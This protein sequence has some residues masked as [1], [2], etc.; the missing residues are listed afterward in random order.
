MVAGAAAPVTTTVNDPWARTHQSAE[1]D[2]QGGAPLRLPEQ[3]LGQPVCRPVGC[4][5]TPY[6]DSGIPWTAE[7]LDES[8]GTGGQDL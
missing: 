5:R 6:S 3:P 4:P 1:G 2:F 7:V 8:E